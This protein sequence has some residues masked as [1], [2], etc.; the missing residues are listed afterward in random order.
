[1]P[2][3]DASRYL[4]MHFFFEVWVLLLYIYQNT[5][6]EVDISSIEVVTCCMDTVDSWSNI[7]SQKFNDANK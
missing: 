1:M 5:H 3:L 4:E 2:E 6:I 7:P